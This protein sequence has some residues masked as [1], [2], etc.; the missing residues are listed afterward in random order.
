MKKSVDKDS[1]LCYPLW[2]SL[3]YRGIVAKQYGACKKKLAFFYRH[4][5]V[6]NYVSFLAGNITSV[7]GVLPTVLIVAE[8][9]E[10]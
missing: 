1:F 4:F 3:E 5:C 6:I 7:S 2:Y 10:K 9:I 8:K